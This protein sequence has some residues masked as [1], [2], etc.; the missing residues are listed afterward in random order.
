MLFP[1]VPREA[2]VPDIDTVITSPACIVPSRYQSKSP[3]E[4]MAPVNPS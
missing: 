2:P 1:S 3:L 4:P